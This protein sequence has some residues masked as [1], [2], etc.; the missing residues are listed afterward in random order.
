MKVAIQLDRPIGDH[1]P[2]FTSTD[3]VTGTV[4]LNLQRDC[5]VSRITLELSGMYSPHRAIR[6]G[7]QESLKSL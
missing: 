4:H 1:D 6:L 2:P 5:A 7:N 3:Y